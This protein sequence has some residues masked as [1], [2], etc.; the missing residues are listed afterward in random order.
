M[1]GTS[2]RALSC[3]ALSLVAATSSVLASD[4][5]EAPLIQEDPS[6]DIADVYAF[7]SPNDPDALVLAMT[8]NA[9]SVPEEA[10]AFNFSN[11]ASYRFHIDRTGDAVSDLD[12][13]VAVTGD[14]YG[15]K[16]GGGLKINGAPVTMP[17]EEPVPNPPLINDHDSGIRYR[18]LA[19]RGC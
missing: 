8:V 6:A 9:F 7:V 1:R 2:C 10:I 4:H 11:N 12:I 15:I 19:R 18:R 14:Q 16:V 3:G 13:E 17:S 5:R